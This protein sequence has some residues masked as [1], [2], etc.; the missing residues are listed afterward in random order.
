MLLDEKVLVPLSIPLFLLELR[1]SNENVL[2]YNDIGE[3]F[4]SVVNISLI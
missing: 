3:C 4:Q 1:V 2:R